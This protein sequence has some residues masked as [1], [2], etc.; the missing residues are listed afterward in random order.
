MGAAEI[1]PIGDRATIMLDRFRQAPLCPTNQAEK[2]VGLGHIGV[3]GEGTA[4][5]FRRFAE[6][7]L[8]IL[9]RSQLADYGGIVRFQRD[10]LTQARDRLVEPVL[11]LEQPAQIGMGIGEGRI[12]RDRAAEAFDRLVSPAERGQHDAEII[13]GRSAIR[14]GRDRV[15]QQLRRTLVVGPTH[16]GDAGQMKR[17]GMVR[18]AVEDRR[19]GCLG[20]LEPPRGV[21]RHRRPVIRG[22]VDDRLRSSLCPDRS[23]PGHQS[24]AHICDDAIPIA[25][26]V[27]GG[28]AAR[29]GTTGCPGGRAASASPARRPA[30]PKPAGRVRPRD[31]PPRCRPR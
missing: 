29:S 9:C 20:L 7:I 18:V 22:G 3:E 17:A 25:R 24:V 21:M 13:V 30:L 15:L 31:V 8:R 26:P 5:A 16:L 28:T 6:M 4:K 12:E 14:I 19:R 1:G 10:R 27:P 2:V 23:R 11:V